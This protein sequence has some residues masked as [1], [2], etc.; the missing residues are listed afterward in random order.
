MQE[1]KTII[2]IGPEFQC[3]KE[4]G[5][6]TNVGKRKVVKTNNWKE[7]IAMEMFQRIGLEY[8]GKKKRSDRNNNIRKDRAGIKM[9]QMIQTEFQSLKREGRN[10]NG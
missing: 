3:L 1:L 6:N 9:L 8:Q 10:S 7:W 5:R 4:K 2:K